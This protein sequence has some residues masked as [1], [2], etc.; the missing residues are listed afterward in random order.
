MNR[1]TRT[2]NVYS[3][4]IRL[5]RDKMQGFLA[6][7]DECIYCERLPLADLQIGPDSPTLADASKAS[8]WKPIRPGETWGGRNVWNW[9]RASA[10]IPDAWA[11]RRVGLFF[12]LGHPSWI[13]QPE[14]LAYIDGEYRQG[15]DGFHHEILLAEQAVAGQCYDVALRVW[16]TMFDEVT[17]AI[18]EQIFGAGDLVMIDLPTRH[19][20]HSVE[21]ALGA[22][23]YIEH[24]RY[25]FHLILNA[26]DAAY[27]ELDTRVL[28]SPEF[29]QSVSRAQQAMDRVL[30][31]IEGLPQRIIATGHAHIDVLWRWRTIN[32]REKTLHTFGTVLRLMEQY[33]DFHFTQS[34][35][36]LYQYVQHDNPALYEQIKARIREGRWEALG[37]MWVE[38]DCNI[39]S[40]ESLVRQLLRGRT[41]FRKEFGVDDPLLWLPDTFGYSW[42][43]PQLIQR[44]GMRYFFTS[45]IS[46]NQYNR[47]PYDSFWW[48]GIDG[49]TVLTHFATAPEV[50]PF[51]GTSYNAAVTGDELIRTWDRYQQKAENSTLLTAFGR[52]DG[53][54]GP[55]IGMIERVMRAENHPGLP[56]VSQGSVQEFFQAL[57]QIDKKLPVWNGELYLEYHRGTYTSQSR[58]KRSNRKAEALCHRAELA[59]SIATL[60][61]QPY[62][63]ERLDEG[64]RLILLNQFHDVI[65]GSS[66]RE[67]YEDSLQEYAH[68][69]DIGE[70]VLA[71]SLQAIARAL[72]LAEGEEAL[73]V[74]Q[75]SGVNSSELHTPV[76]LPAAAIPEGQVPYWASTG[77]DVPV[78]RSA[79][80]VYLSIGGTPGPSLRLL[81]LG[82]GEPSAPPVSYQPRVEGHTLENGFIRV[83]L[84]ELGE[85][86][87]LYDKQAER[88]LIPAGSVGNQMQ[89]FQDRPAR[90]DAWDIDIT[91]EDR[92]WLATP[93]SITVIENGPLVAAVEVRKTILDAQVVQIIALGEDARIDFETHVVW[94]ERHTLLKVAFPVDIL[95]PR[96]TFDIQFGNVERPTHRNTSWDWARYESVA[97]KWVDLSEVDYGVSL[98]ND[99]KYGHDIQD[100]VIRLSLLRAPTYPDPEADQGEQQF[101]YSLLPHSGSLN[102]QTIAHAYALNDPV[103]VFPV[104]GSGNPSPRLA[105]STDLFVMENTGN[106]VIETVKAAENGRGLIVRLYETRRSRGK[107]VLHCGFPI[108]QVWETNLMEDDEQELSVHDQH[109]IELVFTPFQIRTL[110]I[111]PEQ[112]GG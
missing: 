53:G 14:A 103:I 74:F 95:S 110:R 98:L 4:D 63:Y 101:T 78:Q 5:T 38:A 28:R 55:T 50:P 91:Y 43:L 66:I 87:S 102:M 39:P 51:T 99:C 97:H 107:A 21:L 3:H 111:I 75:P 9:F 64:W 106:I 30:F 7:L 79:E 27:Q 19:L 65:P 112:K 80:T 15:I 22:L 67:V 18:Y 69:M 96:A 94:H 73:L 33:P 104:R 6:T 108:A 56:R 44:S 37:G 1:D 58:S 90:W 8:G 62:P 83:V 32:T 31:Q 34:Q 100:N 88:E 72:P 25:E 60:V 24:N 45:K 12:A 84:N 105:E 13:A 54:G 10:R 71:E 47:L 17:T 20:Y 40:G 109:E 48:R 29:Y 16:C 2:V 81:R 41:Y 11:G 89:A 36:Q 35:P 76:K 42:A 59:A 61:G 23:N 46:W 26:L 49:T 68:V 85:I 92:M 70:A 57:E 52:G 93:G 86:V 82:E 77:E